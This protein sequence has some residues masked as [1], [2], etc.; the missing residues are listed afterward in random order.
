MP[1]I[2]DS[3]NNGVIQN[4]IGTPTKN[5]MYVNDNLLIDIWDRLKIALVYSIEALYNIFAT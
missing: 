3:I 1:T 2:V 5:N 4:R